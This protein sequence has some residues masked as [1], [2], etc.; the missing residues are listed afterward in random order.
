MT[1]MSEGPANWNKSIKP[2]AR[3]FKP[4][5]EMNLWIEESFLVPPEAQNLT[6]L[7]E[8]NPIIHDDDLDSAQQKFLFK[9]MKDNFLHHEA[10]SIVKKRTADKDTRRIWQELCD[11]YDS[12][13][14]AAMCADVLMTHLADIEPHKANWNHGQSEFINHYKIQKNKFKEIAPDSIHA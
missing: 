10:K 11:F 9:A 4:F 14:T 5:G 13:I 7:V 6:H 2:N 12:L 1:A 3:D 8:M